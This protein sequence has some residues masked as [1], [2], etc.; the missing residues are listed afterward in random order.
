MSVFRRSDTSGRGIDSHKQA[1]ERLYREEGIPSDVIETILRQ[2]PRLRLY[3]CSSGC[4]SMIWIGESAPPPCPVCGKTQTEER[5]GDLI[6]EK[7]RSK[8]KAGALVMYALKR[9]ASGDHSKAEALLTRA[10]ELDPEMEVAYHNRSEERIAQENLTGGL[11]DCNRVIGM[12][13]KAADAY[14]TRSG[15]KAMLGDY[16]GAAEDADMALKLGTT[17]P[18]AYFNRG[19]CRLFAGN[20]QGGREDLERFLQLAR[21][22]DGRAATVREILRKESETG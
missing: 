13:P 16:S 6:A 9:G 7:L 14:L 15:A 10:I 21:D 4:P 22:D 19:V 17:I 5:M 2:E 12:N 1:L 11:E 3:L 8:L 18:V 20:R